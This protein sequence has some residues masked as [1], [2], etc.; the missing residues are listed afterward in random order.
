MNKHVRKGMWFI[1]VFTLV[2]LAVL[3]S[4][5]SEA[6]AQS[7]ILITG[8]VTG[9]NNQPL[10]GVSVQVENSNVG[11]ATNTTGNFSINAPGNATL[12]FSYIGY[13]DTTVAVN[14]RTSLDVQLSLGVSQ[15]NQ[16]V[17]IGYGTA[18]KRDL[19]G[20]ISR[21]AGKD[22]ADKPNVNPVASLQGRVA[23]LSI[24]NSGT[25]GAQPDVRIRGTISIGSV[26]PVYVVDGILNDNIDFVNPNDIES[27]EV[28]KDPSSLAIFGV[29]GAAGAIVI[30]TKRAKAGQT[31]INFNSN[32]GFK[33]LVDKIKLTNAEQFKTLYSEQL[34]NEGSPAFDFS[35]W[36]G[37]TDWIDVLSQTGIF[38]S[39]NIGI[40]ASSEKNRFY[41]NVGYLH[42]EGIVKHEQLDKITLTISDEYKVSK[43]LRVGFNINAMRQDLPYL[44]NMG[45]TDV[46]TN[47]RRLA[48][49]A[50]AGTING[51]YSSLPGF[52]NAQIQNPILE[53]ENKYNTNSQIEY[54]TVGN[55]FA[56]I[57]FLKNFTFRATGYGDITNGNTTSYSP[58]I[59]YY[60]PDQN[61]SVIVD[62]SYQYTSLSIG[63]YRVYK[64]QQDNILTFKKDFGA[65][66]LT[67]TVGS[68]IYYEGQFNNTS[69]GKQSTTGDPIPN[70][71]RMWY[72]NNAL[73]DQGSVRATSSQFERTTASFLARVLYNYKSKYL[74][75]ASFRTDGTS[76][77]ANHPTQNFWAVGAAWEL[78]RED[79]M[80]NQQIFDLLKIKGS[81]GVL[82]NQSTTYNNG[83]TNPYPSYAPLTA[84]SAVFGNTL[85][86][87]YSA[88]YVP[89]PNLRWE[90]VNAGEG[91]IELSAFNRRLHFEGVYYEKVTHDL[92][93]I[94]PAIGTFPAR[95]SNIG[96]I[97]NKGFE[98]SAGWTQEFS[99]DFSITI[100][101]NLTTLKNKVLTLYTNDPEG[102]TGASEEYPNRT[103]VGRPI[104]FFY[105]YVVEGVYQDS[106]EIAKSPVV[107]G[108]GDY[109]PGDLKFKD[110]DGN[111]TINTR[112]RTMIGNPTPKFTYGLSIGV[113][114]KGFDLGIDLQGV[115]GNQIYRYWGT[116]ELTFAPFNYPAWKMNRWHGPGTSNWVP[117]VNNE[118]NINSKAL[119][120]FGIENGS[121]LRIRNLQLGY[122]FRTNVLQRMNIKSFRI[123]VSAQNIKTFKHNYGYT[124]EFGGSATSFGIDV[125][126]GVLP[127]VYTA[128]INVTF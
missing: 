95:L 121:Y 71:K 39:N 117:Q 111:D 21:V 62:P 29:R 60:L 23:G 126:N 46:L 110:L 67:A 45:Y 64:W 35:N 11:T 2:L 124:P 54:R 97:S 4:V 34:Q 55:I 19:T 49:V 123:F 127:A 18:N 1:R 42:D 63:N 76:G 57:S 92:L 48:P 47:A 116:S 25:P 115:S 73:V 51:V 17:V 9:E 100:N 94:Q 108:Y 122:N 24:V 107:T 30:T 65:H 106:A 96:S 20:S 26:H 105:G 27:I 102:I 125:G 40:T 79:F 85:Y 99:K 44:G 104:G 69:T 50:S 43:A 74:L 68:T 87:A 88:T 84:G 59:N 14:G 66:A 103:A 80:A 83:T 10:A 75:N 93:A 128:G 3:L 36:T 16:V 7:P 120:T 90:T 118:H 119:S 38:S 78:S 114:F 37:N 5:R 82:G 113:N 6:Q 112:D 12:L 58:I 8:R 86:P 89:D 81:Y 28:L 32:T 98:F 52:Q 41:M 56:E 33:K 61:D 101:G 31:L 77:F 15:L 70:D 91:G 72:I 53:L 13:N 109:G 22:I